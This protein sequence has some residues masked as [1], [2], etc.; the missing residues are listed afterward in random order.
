MSR[1]TDQNQD[2]YL[3]RE[4]FQALLDVLQDAGF[5]CIGPQIKE[6]A[7]VFNNIT[8][9]GQLPKGVVDVQE[10]GR[11]T[12]QDIDSER[13]F[14]WATGPQALKPHLF[15]PREILWQ[16]ARDDQGKLH[17]TTACEEQERLAF[18]G[19]RSCDLAALKLH[20]Q[21]FLQS[22]YTDNAYLSRR[23]QAF[24]VA[25]NCARSAATCF[26]HS[27]GDGPRVRSE[28]DL[29]L[30]ELDDGFIVSSG[31]KKGDEIF[32]RLPLIPSTQSQHNQVDQEIQS[33]EV[34]QRSLP[35]TDLNKKLMSQLDHPRWDELQQRC[36]SCGN[37]TSV[38]PTCFCHSE[39]DNPGLDGRT[40]EHTREWDSCFTQGHSYI[41]GQVLRDDTR[42]R[43]RQWLTH[44]L[45]SWHDQYQRSGCVGCGRC[46]TWC[47]VGIDIT[48]EV[49][50]ICGDGDHG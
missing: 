20:D 17:F 31:S 4:H 23:K 34:Q 5:R 41:H 22:E 16:V 6:G 50:A 12:L 37:C 9:T 27:T 47:P 39:I 46:I 3:A 13:F 35:S 30:S 8:R 1:D 33:A 25:V 40:S 18:I 45:A 48:V 10:P 32:S 15:L 42:K 49:A 11:Y 21:H 24:I 26:C 38:C 44:K 28:Y 43:Y 36:L 19:I 14:Y 2:A 7:I 29:L